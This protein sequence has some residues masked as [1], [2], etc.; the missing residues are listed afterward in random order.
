M[1]TVLAFSKT[2]A[3]E[4]TPENKGFTEV[5]RPTRLLQALNLTGEQIQQ[6]RRINAARRPIMQEA[7][8]RLRLANRNLDQ[9]IYADEPNEELVKERA[10]EASLAQAEVIKERTITEFMI[11]KVLTPE[12]LQ[13][14]RELREKLQQQRQNM[15]ENQQQRQNQPRRNANRQNQNN[16]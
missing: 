4:Q 14:F 11:R 2:N 8:Q 10:K 1:L 7:Q 16:F 5:N 9:A 12:Q 15:Q 6:I 13:K 3:Q